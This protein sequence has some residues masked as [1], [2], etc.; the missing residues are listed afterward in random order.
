MAPARPSGGWITARKYEV[1]VAAVN[2]VGTGPYTGEQSATP[3]ARPGAP[4]NLSAHQEN[5]EGRR[6]IVAQWDPPASDGGS[7]ITGYRVQY[8]LGTSGA[9]LEDSDHPG[10][11]SRVAGIFGVSRGTYQVRVAAVNREGTGIYATVSV[12]VR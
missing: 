12:R 2:D 3:S 6:V 8:R 5:H 1:R 10:N 7:S 9:W 4:L 11:R